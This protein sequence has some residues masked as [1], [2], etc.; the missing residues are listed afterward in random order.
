MPSPSTPTIPEALDRYLLTSSEGN[1]ISIATYLERGSLLI[2]PDAILALRSLLPALRS[3][4]A[5][6]KDADS[7]KKRIQILLAYFDETPV[8]RSGPDAAQRDIAFAL[9]YFL[10]GYNR[11]PDSIPEIGLL[12][13][14][15]IVNAV[16]Q[17]HETALRTHWLKRGRPWPALN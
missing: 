14:A 12:D 17:W 3:K 2:T 10:K 4:I 1:T 16:L 9:F 15:I 11:I 13:D 8:A 6:I 7:L 5:L